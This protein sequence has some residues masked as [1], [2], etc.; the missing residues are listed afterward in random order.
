MTAQLTYESLALEWSPK[1]RRDDH[2]IVIVV[3]SIIAIMLLGL[4]LSSIELPEEDRKSRSVVSERVAQMVL[5]LE[6]Q[7]PKPK[8]PEVKLKPPPPKPKP[9]EKEK[10]VVVKEREKEKD[11]KPLTVEEKD[12]REKAKEFGILALANDLAD[13]MDTSSVESMIEQRVAKASDLS[14]EVSTLNKDL[15]TAN[16]GE[17]SQGIS[18]DQ[19]QLVSVSSTKLTE[20]ERMLVRQS[21]LSKEVEDKVSKSTDSNSSR[22]T[23]GSRRAEEE[24]TLV[25]D[26]NKGSLYSIYNRERRKDPGLQGKIV[27]EI[28]ISPEGKVVSVIIISSELNNPKLERSLLSR[29]KLFK[30]S[31]GKTKPMTVRYPIEFLPA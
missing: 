4:Y 15:L 13:L 14:R 11:K 1:G 21:L 10:P 20:R 8:P 26:Q 7:K 2:F 30:F 18:S 12:A 27:L 22:G 31:S 23:N 3:I 9:I 5:E 28:T 25:F 6:K 29:I 16:I 24:I 17:G 19:Y